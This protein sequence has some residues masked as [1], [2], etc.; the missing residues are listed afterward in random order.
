MG[1]EL[2]NR[3]KQAVHDAVMGHHLGQRIPTTNPENLIAALERILD[4]VLNK[5]EPV[6]ELAQEVR[7]L[8]RAV[9]NLEKPTPKHPDSVFESVSIKR[10]VHTQEGL[11]WGMRPEVHRFWG[12]HM[13]ALQ[14]R[15]PVRF[16]ND[17]Q[18]DALRWNGTWYTKAAESE[19]E[20]LEKEY[21]QQ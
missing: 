6:Q 10:V 2:K 21:D 9:E 18:P 3:I 7:N 11:D 8:A 14:T 5:P 19:A 12:P 15:S 4:P 17:A 20:Y 16:S 13:V 1:K